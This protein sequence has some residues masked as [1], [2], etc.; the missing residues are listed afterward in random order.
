MG[1][2]GKWGGAWVETGAVVV[3]GHRL[4][5]GSGE[6]SFADEADA[7]GT[8]AEVLESSSKVCASAEGVPSEGGECVEY[9]SGWGEGRRFRGV[10]GGEWCCGGGL[11]QGKEGQEG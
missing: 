8:V 4:G 11:E 2:G 7:F 3:G 1:F 5:E 10:G 6:G 9:V